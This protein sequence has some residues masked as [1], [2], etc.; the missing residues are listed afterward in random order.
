MAVDKITFCSFHGFDVFVQEK[1][2]RSCQCLQS[3]TRGP[4]LRLS[5]MSCASFLDLICFWLFPT[6]CWHRSMLMNMLFHCQQGGQ[7]DWYR[8]FCL[9][10]LVLYY[11]FMAILFLPHQLLVV[12]VLGS[13]ASYKKND[14]I[15]LLLEQLMTMTSI[16]ADLCF[17]K[18]SHIASIVQ[19]G[20]H[21]WF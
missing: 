4:F 8:F 10:C 14:L 18:W 2:Q 20:W 1:R 12:L 13:G 16:V 7:G 19:E 11:L 9:R 5:Q 6:D 15:A 17:K 21:S 3:F